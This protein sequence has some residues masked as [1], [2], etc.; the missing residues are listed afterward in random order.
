VNVLRK[1]KVRAEQKAA[2]RVRI[3]EAARSQLDQCG[4]EATNIRGIAQAAGVS[5]G[6][7]L[8]HFSDKQDLLHA[9]LF[10]D[11]ERRWAKARGRRYGSLEA[12]LT[13][14]AKTFFDYYADRPNLSRA[15]LRES[16]FADPP[17]NERFA[18]Q[19]ADV[20][21]HV[22]ALFSAAQARGE[23]S[24]SAD[25]SVFGAAFLSF[26][27]FA[28]LAWLQGGLR[29]PLRLFQTLLKSHLE[30]LA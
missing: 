14:I 21:G 26:Y 29:N 4:Y 6:A 20:H 9:A 24:R 11:L 17:W 16:L 27:Y 8:L 10:D 5:T 30:N 13:G 2:T 12:A 23:V 1:K 22:A 19:V 28:L 15:L 18:A 25:P 7:V 3:L